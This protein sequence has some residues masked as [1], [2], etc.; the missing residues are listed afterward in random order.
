MNTKYIIQI[1]ILFGIGGFLW[2]SNGYIIPIHSDTMNITNSSNYTNNYNSYIIAY[3]V[4]DTLTFKALAKDNIS[5]NIINSGFTKWDFGDLTETDYGSNKIVTH[6][7]NIPFPYPVSWCGYLNNT[8]YSKALTYNWLV[9]GD[10]SNTKYIFNGSPSNSKTTWD[11]LYNGSNNTVIIKYFSNI[12]MNEEFS[13]LSIDTTQVNVNA[14]KTEI[15]E[16]DTV[17][18]S[19]SVSRN[20]IFTMWSFGDGTFSFEKSPTHTY[21]KPGFYFPRVLVVDDYGRV[22]VGYLD[23]GIH[24]KRHRG[25]YIYWVMGPNHYNGEAHTYVYN[26]SGKHNDNRGN[27]YVNPYKMT[28]NVN[29]SIKF[30]MSGAWGKLWKWDFGDGKETNYAHKNSFNPS[31]H[32]YKFPFMWPFFWMSY[33]K[34]SWWK[35][36][37]L[38]FIVVDDVGNTKYNFH[39]SKTHD[40]KSYDYEYDKENHTVDLYYYSDNPINKSDVKLK[41]GYYIDITATASRTEV[42]VNKKVKFN[43]SPVNNPIFIMWSFGDGTISFKKAPTHKYKNSGLYYPHVFIVDEYGN[44]E[45]GIPSPIGVGGYNS[46]PQIYANPTIAPTNFPI[47]ITIV[48][49]AHYINKI[50]NIYFGDGNSISIKTYHSPYTLNHS[51]SSEGVYHIDMKV[52]RCE[53]GKTVYIIDNKNP[54]AKLYVYPNPASYIDMVS[55][56]PLNSHDPDANRNIPEYDYKGNKIGNYTIPQNSPMAKIYGFNLTVY[57][58]SRNIVWNYSSNELK[59]VTHKFK[60]G[61]YTANLTIWDGMGGKNSTIVEFKVINNPPVADFTYSPTYPK[62]NKQVIFNALSSYDKESGINYSWDFGDGFNANTTNPIITHTYNNP[63]NYTVTLTVHDE[64]N[65]SSSISKILTVYYVKADFGYPSSLKV[66]TTINFI[67]KSNSTPGKIVRWTWD[68]GDGTSSNK[69][70]PSHI[71]PKEGPYYITL[72][73]WNNVG[74]S[75]TVQKPI[76]IEGMTSY[77][78]IAIFDF[79]VNGSNVTFNASKSYDIDGKIVKYIWDFGD[80]TNTTTTNKIISHKYNNSKTYTVKLTIVDN[81]G[82]KDST[83]RFVSINVGGIKRSI[84]IPLPINILLF[85]TTIITIAYIGRWYR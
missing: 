24:V 27:T 12:K 85:I 9:V 3:N 64:L 81:D 80:G 70:N 32:K 16:G 63:G 69:Q 78:P 17:K 34:G 29:D 52:A 28:Y 54:V 50:H 40:K 44:I 66:N 37:T 75:D 48:E 68:F 39:P 51:Y 2:S 15:V 20:I 62:V 8:A 11:I 60:P 10:I 14:D 35:S 65:A 30:K 45:V 43:C 18:F 23:E 74:I 6:K 21:T 31:Y 38:N 25:G 19:Y 33:G 73:V 42:S 77:P 53:N 79:T 76:F 56:N 55:F 57:N 26:S 61:N 84:P 83:I 36:D 49:P 82:N 1:I 7:Y 4:N 5:Q 59:V 41:D 71:Y 72:T 47:N 22:M 46:Y 67:D 58:S 13:G